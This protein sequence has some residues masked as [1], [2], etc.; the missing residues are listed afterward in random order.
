MSGS[1]TKRCRAILLTGRALVALLCTLACVVHAQRPGDAKGNGA[2]ADAE[3]GPERG[4]AAK[5]EPAEDVQADL[6]KMQPSI[7]RAID[8]GV[9]NILSRQLRDGSWGNRSPQ[10]RNG[11]TA[12]A[13]YMLVKSGVSAEHPA[14]ARALDFLG[15]ELPG[16]T[17]SAGC[18]M[19]FYESLHD[20][21]YHPRMQEIFDRLLSWQAQGAWSYPWTH[22]GEG[23][24]TTPGTP[25]LSNMQYAALGILCARRA[26]LDV[27]SKALKLMI[28]RTLEHQQRLSLKAEREL[29]RYGKPR[30]IGFCYRSKR[31]YGGEGKPTGSMTAAGVS[32]LHICLDALGN[33]VG[34]RYKT[35]IQN[36][37]DA[38]V[39]WLAQNF[40]VESNPNNNGWLYYYLYGIERV[41]DLLGIDRIGDRW[42]YRDGAKFIVGKQRDRGEWGDESE[43]CFAVLFL[44]RATSA[45]TGGEPSKPRDVWTS[46]WK[47]SPLAVRASGHGEIVMWV[48][49]FSEKVRKEHAEHGLRVAR[50]EWFVD[51]VKIDTIEG[52]TARA[53]DLEPYGTKYRFARP[54]TYQITAKAY[55]VAP[56]A[57][58]GCDGPLVEVDAKGLTIP[59][60]Q[61]M[62]GWMKDEL[63]ARDRNLLLKVPLVTRASSA[64]KP[65][66]PQNAVDGRQATRWVCDGKDEA[67]T[68]SI[69]L[70]RFVDADRI[71][72]E[73]AVASPFEKGMFDTIRKVRLKLNDRD[74]YEFTMAE[75]VFE[76]STYVFPRKHKIKR[77]DIEVLE[78]DKGWAWPGQAGFTEVRLERDRR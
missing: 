68:L 73:Q 55:V 11:Q 38:G 46:D 25:D 34:D 12:L 32:I 14:I 31:G 60:H 47:T 48:T 13:A 43:T 45:V 42:W 3:Q 35:D 16:E 30:A 33:R 27:P 70:S 15:K 36:E 61:V 28:G 75:D 66:P 65:H 53:F 57:P 56:D 63:D 49:G 50:V 52:S 59:I 78:R 71:V 29:K 21:K 5:V 69:Q 2:K 40:S 8:R 20:P 4:A 7:D 64:Q 77:L 44:K 9:E 17:Y 1:A 6:V 54:G 62:A 74:T 51:E 19:L 67:P 18:Q 22:A 10:Y 76:P 23:W 58:L 24:T 26:G 41:G 39:R 72:L 37:I